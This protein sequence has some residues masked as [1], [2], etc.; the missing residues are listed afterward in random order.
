MN[1][2]IV[3]LF[4]EPTGSL[5]SGLLLGSRRGMSEELTADLQKTGLS[6]IVAIS[7]YNI[8]LVI[9]FV[10]LLL[11]FLSRKLKILFSLLGVVL[12]V[13][14]VGA[15]AA[16][17]RAA[18]MGGIGLLALFYGRQYFVDYA[19]W[20]TAFV[21][22]LVNP[23][24]LTFDSGFHFSFLATMGLI[25]VVPNLQKWARFVPGRFLLRE[26]FLMTIS[27]QLMVLPVSIWNFGGFSWLAPL[28]N[29]VVLP[30]I[31]LV[32]LLSALALLFSCFS[33]VGGE[34]LAF[35]TDL[36]VGFLIWVIGFFADL[37]WGFLF[38]KGLPWW[39][40]M[41]YYGLLYL[42]TRKERRL[43]RFLVF[44]HNLFPLI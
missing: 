4:G 9:L 37:P 25:Y 13:L 11:S 5:V 19:L 22:S 14:L 29:L 7:G 38:L 16:V 27:A 33:F 36:I 42:F 44:R 21:M 30:F 20:L 18:L 31:P 39:L 17:V 43:K 32:M 40:G 41:V 35:L 28:I 2:R 3:Q 6:H 15:G 26:N 24:I 1:R 34:F 12:F 8:T 23:L 10:G